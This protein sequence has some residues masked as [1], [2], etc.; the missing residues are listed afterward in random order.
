M[1]GRAY[2]GRSV[3]AVDA[4]EGDG[5]E[6]LV[7]AGGGG[8]IGAGLGEGGSLGDRGPRGAEQCLSRQHG[9]MGVRWEDWGLEC[10]EVELWFS[11]TR[12]GLLFGNLRVPEAAIGIEFRRPTCWGAPVL[13]AALLRPVLNY[14]NI[15]SSRSATFHFK[16]Q[17][18]HQ[19]IQSLW[20]VSID[21]YRNT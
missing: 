16:G 19:E 10:R 9:W 8:G 15:S 4:E 5:G 7:A 20:L 3:G 17:V 14:E 21:N 1:D 13:S 12:F 2:Q 6:D 11:E 18:H